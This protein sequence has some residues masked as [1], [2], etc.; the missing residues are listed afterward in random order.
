M[1]AAVQVFEPRG[2]HFSEHGIVW[3]RRNRDWL[4]LD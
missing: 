2:I 3:P 1:Q 4:F